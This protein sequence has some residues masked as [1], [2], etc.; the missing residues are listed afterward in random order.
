MG[1]SDDGVWVDGTCGHALKW[2]APECIEGSEPTCESDIYSLAITIWEIITGD[3]PYAN[4]D[5]V[6]TAIHV[7]VGNQRPVLYEY[8]PKELKNLLQ[9]MWKKEPKDRHDASKV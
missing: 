7:L 8:F 9:I 5:A 1:L 6:D 4:I 3:T 2:M